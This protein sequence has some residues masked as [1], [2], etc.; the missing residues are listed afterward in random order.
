VL[1]YTDLS[2]A[3]LRGAD[4]SVADLT[5]GALAGADLTFAT[6]SW[7]TWIDG[8]T[9]AE[10]S[11]GQCLA[12]VPVGAP[13]SAQAAG[14]STAAAA[15]GCPGTLMPG[16]A[17]WCDLNDGTILDMTTGLA[18]LKNAN[19]WGK[20]TK[21]DADQKVALL[22]NGQCGLTDGSVGG[23]WRIPAANELRGLKTGPEFVSTYS[24]NLHPIN[25][26]GFINLAN[27]WYVSST[28]S[29]PDWFTTVQLSFWNDFDG[30]GTTIH[31]VLPVRTWSTPNGVADLSS[32]R[33]FSIS[34]SNAPSRPLTQNLWLIWANAAYVVLWDWDAGSTSNRIWYFEPDGTGYF[35]IYD[36][37]GIQAWRYLAVKNDER[38]DNADVIAWPDR[39]GNNHR[40][41]PVRMSGNVTMFQ[42]ASSGKCLDMRNGGTGNGNAL[43][44]NTC[45]PN[46]A[47][48][49]WV[50]KFRTR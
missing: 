32:G 36:R 49:Q 9:C 41:L 23:E 31:P 17:R 42:S 11:V 40:W 15:S 20:I 25:S 27:S 4:L 14:V 46:R 29:D 10:G 21:G 19:C 47:S 48:Q 16:S 50:L 38:Q 35:R 44:Q 5:G 12:T 26:R 2:E 37:V 3:N 22:G 18:W 43:V 39:G 24:L 6:L 28:Y 1:S 45:D 8:R 33:G 34:P 13:V 7:A 30:C